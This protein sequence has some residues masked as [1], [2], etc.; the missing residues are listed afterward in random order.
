MAAL[1]SLNLVV[2]L[3]CVFT[4]VLRQEKGK[5]GAGFVWIIFAL[6]NGYFFAT[7]LKDFLK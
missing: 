6:L 3:L 2:T 4:S 5:T 1:I 7:N